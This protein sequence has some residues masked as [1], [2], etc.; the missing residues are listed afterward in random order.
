MSTSQPTLVDLTE[1]PIVEIRKTMAIAE[2][3]DFYHQALPALGA[4]LGKHG[5]TPA[6]P[7][8]GISHGMPAETIDLSAAF[9]VSAPAE[10][11]GDV[12][13]ATLPAG[14]VATLTLTGSFDGLAAAYDTLLTWVNEEGLTPGELAWEQY[15]SDP[16]E[17]DPEANVTQLFWLLA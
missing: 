10:A 1:Q 7:P 5:I 8:L 16:G 6:G 4:Y 17:T 2:I 11:D 14:R 15:L 13:P 3:P 12:R 9:P